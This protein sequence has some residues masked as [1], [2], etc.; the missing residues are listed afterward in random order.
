[1]RLCGIIFLLCFLSILGG[2]AAAAA[3]MQRAGPVDGPDAHLRITIGEEELRLDLVVNLL[4]ADAL[5]GVLHED[6]ERLAATEHAALHAALARKLRSQVHVFCAERELVASERGFSVL[7]PDRRLLPL[8]P[9]FGLRALTK[10]RIVLAFPIAAGPASLRLR[11]A[12]F[13][14]DL[15]RASAQ[16]IPPAEVRATIL[17]DG[18]ELQRIFSVAQPD[19]V[20]QR[21]ASEPAAR[22][23]AV[24][25]APLPVTIDLPLLTI[26]LGAAFFLALVLNSFMGSRRRRLPRGLY[27]RRSLG[28][29]VLCVLLGLL[30][31][32][33][34]HLRVQA[35][36]AM[37]PLP[38]RVQ[39]RSVFAALHANL[40]R[41]FDFG[42]ETEIYDALARSVHGR[43][44]EQ[45]YDSLY[46]G[47]L[48]R[49]EGDT[50]SRVRELTLLAADVDE[51][52][53]SDGRFQFSLRARWRVVADLSHWGHGHQRTNEYE[54]HY[55]V[56][57]FGKSWRIVAY[58]PLAARRIDP[59]AA[60]A[61]RTPDAPRI[62]RGR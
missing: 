22:F 58:Q 39:A 36:L 57:S 41:G 32:P 15:A 59:N 28:L 4:F 3:C 13:P 52:E 20:W 27:W 44:L 9:R 30:A 35:P 16:G 17:A 26:G 23:A 62:G 14:P 37:Q 51:P 60:S 49:E 45:L 50:L 31:W 1:M 7:D 2:P 46:R 43:L 11:W 24:A 18:R 40:Y 56:A 12:A 21:G 61:P 55:S 19:F 38:T 42:T 29:A 5:L 8:F 34:G 48:M 54:A 6:R 47:L 53:L 33:F 25:P 10:L